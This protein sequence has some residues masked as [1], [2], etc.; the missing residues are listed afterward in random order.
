MRK[1]NK[2]KR[3]IEL[4]IK[5]LNKSIGKLDPPHPHWISSPDMDIDESEDRCYKCAKKKAEELSKKLKKEVIVD[6]GWGQDSNDCCV[7]CADCGCLLTYSLTNHGCKSELDHFDIHGFN[8][9]SDDEAYHLM[10]VLEC[11][12]EYENIRDRIL[13]L[14]KRIL[15]NAK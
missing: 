7:H 4:A 11:Y 15:E 9:Y 1:I 3:I 5:R 8:V 12:E 13:Q 10:E 2:E 6:G 14:S